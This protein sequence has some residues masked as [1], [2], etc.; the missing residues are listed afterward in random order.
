L[1][2]KMCCEMV[3]KKYLM[4]IY[5]G[6]PVIWKWWRPWEYISMFLMKVVGQ[7]ESL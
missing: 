3:S 4:K 6:E 7:E 2:E 1:A 5:T